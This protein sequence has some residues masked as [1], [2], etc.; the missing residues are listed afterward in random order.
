MF[1][2]RVFVRV[3]YLVYRKGVLIHNKNNLYL[4]ILFMDSSRRKNNASTTLVL[5]KGV[6]TCV[7][8]VHCRFSMQHQTALTSDKVSSF[9]STGLRF[10]HFLKNV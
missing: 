1:F 3:M 6:E 5:F 4:T 10:T 2:I 7:F 8:I 9:G